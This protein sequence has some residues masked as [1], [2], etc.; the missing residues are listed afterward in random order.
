[1]TF[2]K[3]RNVVPFKLHLIK[4]VLN[5]SVLSQCFIVK[6]KTLLEYV[7]MN[8]SFEELSARKNHKGMR[9]SR[10]SYIKMYCRNEC[11]HNQT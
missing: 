6:L 9:R 7:Q 10:V 3:R 4:I 1:M 2:S 5:F 11:D 8:R